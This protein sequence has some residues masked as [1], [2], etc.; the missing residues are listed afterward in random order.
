MEREPAKIPVSE[1]KGISEEQLFHRTM[2]GL[3]ITAIFSILFYYGLYRA[4][5]SVAPEEGYLMTTYLFRAADE[6]LQE[7]YDDHGHFPPARDGQSYLGPLTEGLLMPAQFLAVRPHYKGPP[8]DP[9]RRELLF[10]GEQIFTARYSGE[11]SKI[12]YNKNS[13][14]PP[15]YYRSAD[16][17]RVILMSNGP[18][19]DPDLGLKELD[20]MISAPYLQ[21]QQYT[22]DVTNG[23]RSDGDL[24]YIVE[25]QPDTVGDR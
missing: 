6:G 8:V 21:L 11:K 15:R 14:Y 24:I 22:Y 20:N 1:R 19:A 10:P 16:G 2:L 18:D 17:Q 3:F 7:F 4:Y 23:S 9:F 5:T 25:P 12:F 13:G